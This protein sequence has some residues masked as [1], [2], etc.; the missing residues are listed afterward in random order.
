MRILIRSQYDWPPVSPWEEGDELIRSWERAERF[1]KR[2]NA[3]HPLS[4]DEERRLLSEFIEEA[5]RWK[6]Q[7]TP[8]TTYLP[9]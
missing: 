2:Y 9:S 1:C 8:P 6:S 7:R 5:K 3:E 4:E